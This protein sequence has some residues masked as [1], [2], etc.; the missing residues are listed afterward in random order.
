MK[1]PLSEEQIEIL[2]AVENAYNNS[3]GEIIKISARSGSGKTFMLTE[4]SKKLNPN[5]GMYLA[6]NK[7]IAD[8][9]KGKFA[10]TISC[11][12]THSLAYGNIV[13][14]LGLE[15]GFF[16]YKNIR[17]RLQFEEKL[18]IVDIIEKF[19]LSSATDVH[20]LCKENYPKNLIDV[21][22]SYMQKMQRK[23]ISCT[24]SFYLKL[25][26]LS[27]KA[28]IIKPKEIDLLMLDEAGDINEVTLSIFQLIPAKIK[29]LVGDNH[30]NIYSFNGTINGFEALKNVGQYY[31]LTKSFRVSSDIAKGVELF[32]KKYLDPNVRFIGVDY[33]HSEINSETYAFISRT[34]ASMIGKMIQLDEIN[35]K[36]NLVRP[37]K[38]IFELINILIFLKP[39][40][41][42]YN[43]K[44]KFLQT[45]T[46]E[47]Y[48]DP[49]LQR[50]FSNLFA[51]I[52]ACNE[53]DVELASAMSLINRFSK[54][55]IIDT[56]NNALKHEK[57][58]RKHKI[59][60]TTAHSSK[61]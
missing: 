41:D 45:E 4:I 47:Y 32:C 60:L 33:K 17:E 50:E 3:C 24:H 16:S 15:V 43:A 5:T 20:E 54:N 52:S 38:N 26:Q 48:E 44:Y 49:S 11:R 34:N 23:E 27:L 28:G 55:T 7:A 14:G 58:T 37:V 29:I 8:E 42:V 53:G 31:E 35:T 61:G 2:N 57:D 39:N 18:I 36:Y 6:Y 51:Y 1:K 59:W 19:C 56:Y 40:G 25:Y 22:K 46:D 21:A 13:K 10:D 9:S 12:T 30:Q